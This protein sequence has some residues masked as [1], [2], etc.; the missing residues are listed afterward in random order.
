MNLDDIDVPQPE[1][2]LSA[3]EEAVRAEFGDIDGQFDLHDTDMVFHTTY[4]DKPITIRGQRSPVGLWEY[5]INGNRASLPGDW[6]T[7]EAEDRQQLLVAEIA[8]WQD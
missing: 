6:R 8:R 3:F 7:R 5:V 1:A 4:Q 2:A